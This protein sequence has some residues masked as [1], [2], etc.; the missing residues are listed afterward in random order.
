VVAERSVRYGAMW[1]AVIASDDVPAR[2]IVPI[3]ID[4][5]DAVVWRSG[6]G[7]PR[8]VGRWCPHLDWD[9]ADAQW[10]GEELL[11][12]AHGWSILGDGRA[13]K[14]N[15]HGRVDDKGTTRT[16]TLREHDG[17]IEA[18]VD[19]PSGSSAPM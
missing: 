18:A 14:R 11:C 3:T 1:H 17:W 7:T 12:F 5:E 2:T 19:A 8:A 13:C 16:W 6:D 9:L 4:G 15:E 10:R